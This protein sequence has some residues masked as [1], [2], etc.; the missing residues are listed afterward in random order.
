M[1]NKD[2][3]LSMI[4]RRRAL[5][6][7]HFCLLYICN[8]IHRTQTHGAMLPDTYMPLYLQYIQNLT[9]FVEFS[10]MYNIHE[11]Q[12]Y[13]TQLSQQHCT[14]LL[15]TTYT[16]YIQR[17]VYRTPRQNGATLLGAPKNQISNKHSCPGASRSKD[18]QLNPGLVEIWWTKL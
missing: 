8:N 6:T 2:F 1:Q 7:S 5:D 9:I 13:T 4:E 14:L 18:D 17:H 15:S 16:T 11:Q 3:S 10:R 12:L